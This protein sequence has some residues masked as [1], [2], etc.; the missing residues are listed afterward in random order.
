MVG[1]FQG[2]PERLGGKFPLTMMRKLLWTAIYSIFAALAALAA[3]N[4]ASRVYRL[5]TGE[6]PPPRR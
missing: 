2:F 4:A 3:R 5:T 1:V 6:E